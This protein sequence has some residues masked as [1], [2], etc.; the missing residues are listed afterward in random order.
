MKVNTIKPKRHRRT[1]AQMEEARRI[2]ALPP[3]R[4]IIPCFVQ[5]EVEIEDEEDEEDEEE[6]KEAGELSIPDST[7][8]YLQS[9]SGTELLSKE[10]EISIAKEIEDTSLAVKE[11][12][13][14]FPSAVLF[15][16]NVIKEMLSGTRRPD[17]FIKSQED[18]QD[19]KFDA[20]LFSEALARLNNLR[21]SK[22]TCVQGPLHDILDRLDLNEKIDN[23]L[24]QY[25]EL[26]AGC[27]VAAEKNFLAKDELVAEDALTLLRAEKLNFKPHKELSEQYAVFISAVNKQKRAK[28]KMIKS[29]LRLVISIAKKYINKGMPLLDIIQEGNIGLMKAIDKFEYKRGFKFSTYAT[30]WIRQAI[31]HAIADKSRL[32]RVPIHMVETINKISSARNE[33]TI[34]EEQEPTAE[35]IASAVDI[36]TTKV[37]GLLSVARQPVS[38]QMSVGSGEDATMEDFIEDD[39]AINPRVNAAASMVKENLETVLNEALTDRERAIIKMRFGLDEDGTPKT[40]EDVGKKFDVTRERIRQIEAKA[41][42]KLRHPAHI[43]RLECT[44]SNE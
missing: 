8:A 3:L 10:A 7:K 37:K 26:E 41:L 29:N 20:S 16:I 35:E 6:I 21:E 24:R 28:E 1:K 44:L 42:K 22:T 15:Y 39:S 5:P 33:L 23:E 27:V 13:F 11:A 40:L 2:A 4:F 36:P 19:S 25:V 14:N 38:M 43:K 34:D 12:A 18:N 9:V 32:I 30:W 31:T 17:S